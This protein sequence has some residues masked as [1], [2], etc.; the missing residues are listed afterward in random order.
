MAIAMRQPLSK[1][2]QSCHHNG[3]HRGEI[4]LSPAEAK[5][6]LSRPLPLEPGDNCGFHGGARGGNS[7]GF[8]CAGDQTMSKDEGQ[9]SSPKPG[10][11]VRSDIHVHTQQALYGYPW[12]TGCSRSGLLEAG[13]FTRDETSYAISSSAGKGTRSA[14]AASSARLGLIQAASSCSRR[15]TGI[16]V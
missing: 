7:A 15:I 16:R 3:G 12:A 5:N 6:P 10:Q 14:C 4:G 2:F 11:Q 13:E 9:R 8:L 1:V